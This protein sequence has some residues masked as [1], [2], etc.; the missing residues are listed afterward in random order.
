LLVV[1]RFEFCWVC[2]RV[3]CEAV[4]DFMLSR[5]FWEQSLGT[6]SSLGRILRDFRALPKLRT[7]AVFSVSFKYSVPFN[8]RVSDSNVFSTS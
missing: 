8:F 5:R 6:C 2:I 1:V 3:M 4:L 7:S